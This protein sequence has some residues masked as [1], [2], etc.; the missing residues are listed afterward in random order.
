MLLASIMIISDAWSAH[1]IW[2]PS[3]WKKGSAGY[4]HSVFEREGS[5]CSSFLYKGAGGIRTVGRRRSWWGQE[6]LA[7]S[8][9]GNRLGIQWCTGGAIV[10]HTICVCMRLLCGWLHWCAQ[11]GRRGILAGNANILICSIATLNKC[12]P[13]W[14]A[15]KKKWGW[16]DWEKDEN[17]A[18]S[19]KTGS[20]FLELL[21][22]INSAE[23][24][25]SRGFEENCG[26][27]NCTKWSVVMTEISDSGGV[28]AWL[29]GAVLTSRGIHVV[30]GQ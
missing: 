9:H 7:E 5:H 11:K 4:L 8:T 18:G 25:T 22:E 21:L 19:L 29:W 28:K 16:K 26:Q 1:R 23:L 14:Q 20:P 12:V 15:W 30:A 27:N 10:D 3:D 17:L 2:K 13:P 24:A 6:H